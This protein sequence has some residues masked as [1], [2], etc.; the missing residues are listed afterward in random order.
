M[1]N[2]PVRTDGNTSKGLRPVE[3][4]ID[5]LN[6]R[7]TEDKERGNWGLSSEQLDAILS[8]PDEATMWSA[9]DMDSLGGRNLIDVE[10]QINGIVYRESDKFDSG[11]PLG[12]GKY[13][14][15]IV[16]AHRLADLKPITWNTGAVL[17]IGKLRWLEAAE[18]LGSEQA[19]VV[20]RGTEAGAGTVLKLKPV[21]ARAFK[22][23]SEGRTEAETA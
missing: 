21:P 7:I 18:M 13:A 9:D 8:A 5:F 6:R 15:V 12:S 3:K 23:A 16:E 1:A 19:H 11:I 2:A 10:Q 14:Y 4:F 20:I 17:L 22:I